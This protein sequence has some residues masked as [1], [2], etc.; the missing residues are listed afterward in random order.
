[1]K[2]NPGCTGTGATPDVLAAQAA[3]VRKRPSSTDR[4]LRVQGGGNVQEAN[5]G[6]VKQQLRRRKALQNSR[7]AGAQFLAS[8]WLWHSPELEGVG[9]AV[10]L[11]LPNIVD[12]QDPRTYWQCTRQSVKDGAPPIAPQK[13]RKRPAASG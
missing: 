5:F 2:R 4:Q 1:M 6:G 7:H 10:L 8:A 12:R 11:F 13:V 9:K 3:A